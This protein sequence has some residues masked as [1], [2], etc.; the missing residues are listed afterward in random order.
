LEHGGTSSAAGNP[1]DS[2]AYVT[3]RVTCERE[4]DAEELTFS[5]IHIVAQW[6][7]TDANQRV[8][9]VVNLPSG[10]CS[11]GDTSDLDID[12][13]EEGSS[14]RIKT[15][16]PSTMNDMGI[17]HQFWSDAMKLDPNC[18]IGKQALEMKLASMRSRRSWHLRSVATIELPI[19]VLQTPP[20]VYSMKDKSGG[21]FLYIVM[22]AK[23]KGYAANTAFTFQTI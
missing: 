10:T 3:P 14:I 7:D 22:E 21:M 2:S 12:V 18:I 6:L 20:M 9:V 1:V 5:P 15:T 19:Q 17:L 16:W 8:T 13:V 4:L 23:S 11:N